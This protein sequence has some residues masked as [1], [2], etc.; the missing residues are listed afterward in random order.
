MT[1]NNS[2]GPGFKIIALLSCVFVLGTWDLYMCVFGYGCAVYILV[3][4]IT[5]VE[6]CLL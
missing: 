3:I 5:S 1:E 6:N 2:G 4:N